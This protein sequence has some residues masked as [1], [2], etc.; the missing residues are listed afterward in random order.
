MLESV[1]RFN[2]KLSGFCEKEG[3][4]GGELENL[5]SCNLSYTLSISTI[6]AQLLVLMT[7]HEIENSGLD[8]FEFLGF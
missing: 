4:G 3:V 2:T 8:S 6:S 7:V 1:Q 5:L